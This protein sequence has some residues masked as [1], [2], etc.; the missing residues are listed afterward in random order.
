MEMRLVSGRL[1]LATVPAGSGHGDKHADQA[2]LT[3][4]AYFSRGWSWTSPVQC[5]QIR[6][7]VKALLLTVQTATCLPCPHVAGRALPLL[8][9]HTQPTDACGLPSPICEALRVP[10]TIEEPVLSLLSLPC[11]FPPAE[12]PAKAPAHVPLPSA[13]WP[14]WCFLVCPPHPPP[15]PW[16]PPLGNCEP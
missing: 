10:E 8:I 15:Q 1:S 16:H 3:T 5:R 14:A 4:D 7:S 12:T 13:P 9:G 6:F 11:R 2:P